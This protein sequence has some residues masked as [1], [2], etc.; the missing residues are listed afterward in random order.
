MA[1]VIASPTQ[2]T[3]PVEHFASGTDGLLVSSSQDLEAL[4]I[5]AKLNSFCENI[6][7]LKL[8]FESF[9]RSTDVFL[10]RLVNSKLWKERT[11]L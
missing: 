10:P 9:K 8:K 2:V 1:N 5:R 4:D 11:W 3:V 7:L 6:E